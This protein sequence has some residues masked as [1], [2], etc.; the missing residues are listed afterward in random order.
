MDSVKQKFPSEAEQ[1]KDPLSILNYAKQAIA[2]RNKYDVIRDGRVIPVPELESEDVGVYLKV[3][4]SPD[5]KNNPGA[6]E[7]S[8]EV[9]FNTSEEPQTVDLSA[10]GNEFRT[11][12]DT[13]CVSEDPVTLESDILSLPPFGVAVLAE[14]E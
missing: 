11:L 3:S 9:I 4:E 5:G 13:L 12:A 7:E 8:V 6:S 10:S 1:E 2:L 14:A